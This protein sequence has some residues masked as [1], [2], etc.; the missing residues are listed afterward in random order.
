MHVVIQDKLSRLRE[1]HARSDASAEMLTSKLERT[2][3]QLD[4][5]QTKNSDL[6][7]AN[8]ALKRTSGEIQRQLAK[9]QNLETKG[10]QEVETLRKRRIELEVQ[11][12][13]LETR[14]EKNGAL[15]A[16]AL[17]KEQRRVEKLKRGVADWQVL[18]IVYFYGQIFNAIIYNT[19]RSSSERSGSGGSSAT[20]QRGAETS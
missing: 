19:G 16:A 15:S 20:V 1:Q 10:D 18:H 17:E 4:G 14:V 8:E 5:A 2:I 7:R 9:W 13:E 11:V 3:L 6:E 12:K